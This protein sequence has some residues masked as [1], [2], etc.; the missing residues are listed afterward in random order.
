MWLGVVLALALLAPTTPGADDP[1]SAA[2]TL[3]L[4]WHE[5]PARIDRARTLLEGAAGA[6]AGPDTLVELARVWFLVGDFRRHGDA[7]R[8][9]AYERGVEVARRAVA[10][11]PRDDRAHLWLAL[12]S[13]RLAELRGVMRALPLV[14]R[15]REESQTVLTLNPASVEGLLLAASLAAELPNL[16]GGDRAKAETL[17]QRALAIEPTHTGGRLELARLYLAT[18]R[19]RE[20]ER[21]LQRIVTEPAPRD[22][23]RWT[24][25]EQ[26]RA[27]ALLTELYERGLLTGSPESP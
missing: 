17:F 27:R 15:I 18:R 20:A 16:L 10:A 13:G 12:N 25:R 23:P 14:A 21:E 6:G 1:L 26:P 4:A 7:E 19:W 5:E 11:A 3:L 2:R 22:R 8:A 9:A 24:V